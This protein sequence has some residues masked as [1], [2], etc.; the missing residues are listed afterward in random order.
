M[1]APGFG[2]GYRIS[3]PSGGVRYGYRGYLGVRAGPYLLDIG[4]RPDG[5]GSDMNIGYALTGA[6]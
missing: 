2:I 5:G 3:T 1:L 4:Y 6:C